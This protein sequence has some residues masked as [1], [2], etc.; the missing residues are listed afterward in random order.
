MHTQ[1][2]TCCNTST[3]LTRVLTCRSAK[4]QNYH[5]L[6]YRLFYQAQTLGI[7]LL[8]LMYNDITVSKWV[9]RAII[10]RIIFPFSFIIVSSVLIIQFLVFTVWHLYCVLHSNSPCKGL[11]EKLF[12]PQANCH[13][14][15][16][17]INKSPIFCLAP[18]RASQHD[19]MKMITS[20]K[21]QQ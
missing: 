13:E 12:L 16:P 14:N 2:T 7:E 10:I 18:R 17:F 20:T 11:C 3:E 15:N 6:F 9:D 5:L 1:I 4:Q 21:E 8:A 19:Q